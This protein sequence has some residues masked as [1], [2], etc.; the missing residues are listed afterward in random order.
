MPEPPLR[1]SPGRDAPSSSAQPRDNLDRW[2]ERP[3]RDGT[4]LGL[5]LGYLWLVALGIFLLLCAYTAYKKSIQVREYAIGAD[6]FGYLMMAKEVRQGVSH[7][8]PPQFQL[9]SEQTRF[10]IDLMLSRNVPQGLWSE[11]VAPHAHHYFPRA[12]RVGVQYPPGVGL[13]LSAFP[14]GR[15]VARLNKTVV[16]LFLSFG[17]GSL[18]LAGKWRAWISA[19]FLIL[20]A[21]LGLEII[22]RI[23]SLSYSI[24]AVLGPLLLALVL[25]FVSMR[26]AEN[27]R[28]SWISAFF[29]GLCWGFA[30][31][32]RLPVALLL[33]GVFLLLWPQSWAISFRNK[34]IPLAAGVMITGIVPLLCF[35]HA[36]AGAWYLATY[37]PDDNSAPSL[38]AL[39][40][41]IRYYLGFGPGGTYNWSLAWCAI[42]LAGFIVHNYKRELTWPGLS[43]TRLLSSA[44]VLWGVPTAYFLTHS[45]TIP[46]Y[47][48]PSTFGVVLLIALGVFAIESF[49]RTDASLKP[50]PASGLGSLALCLALLP[51]IAGG[52]QCWPVPRTTILRLER[53]ARPHF[54]MPAELSQ[55]QAWIWADLSSGTFWYYANMPAFKINYSDPQTRLLVYQFVYDRGEPQYLVRDSEYIQHVAEEISRLGGILEPRG[56][57]EGFS[58]F[59]INWPKRP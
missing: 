29:A 24:N 43:W 1:T 32:I 55:P 37:G 10:L 9:E 28:L 51:G 21:C 8:Q 12:G 30:I 17:I 47:C 6:P 22:G 36:V 57:V 34:I 11:M 58:Y 26:S 20:A 15:A 52:W 16:G 18:I 38:V 41:N 56:V 50:T 49:N 5:L 19:G 31:L 14:Q 39:S 44:M 7:L 25:V 45:V 13:V 27:V 33:P 54:L 2:R 59:L 40:G 53:R 48:I 42:G 46:Y 3:A 35:Q 4:T 23:D